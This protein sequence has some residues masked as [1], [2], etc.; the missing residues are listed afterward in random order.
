M[1]TGMMSPPCACV[2]ALNALQNSMMLT[3]RCPRAGPT[4]GL[5][6][7]A[8]AGICNLI[9]AMTFFTVFLPVRLRFFHLDEV[10][11][12]RRCA[13]EDTDQHTQL[14]LVG[15]DFLDDA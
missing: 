12:D 6:L 15:F 14:A 3:P 5:G 4:G 11:L 13:T 1:I 9:S 8:P 10:Q 7:A 2:W